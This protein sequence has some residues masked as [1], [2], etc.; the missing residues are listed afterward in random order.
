MTL[1]RNRSAL[2]RSPVI[3]ATA[4][5]ALLNWTIASH[6]QTTAPAANYSTNASSRTFSESAP[7]LLKNLTVSGFYQETVGTFLDSEAIEYNKYSKNSLATLRQLLQIDVNDQLSEHDTF[8]MRDWFVYEPSYPFEDDCPQTL[9]RPPG[10]CNSDFYNQYGI[11]ELWLKDTRGPLELYIGRQIVTWGESLSFRVGDQINPQDTSWAFGFSNLEQSRIP[12][13]MLHPILNLPDAGPLSS[14]FLELVY[15]P[16]VDFLY[17]QVDNSTDTIDGQDQVAGRVNINAPSGSRFAG[18][19]DNR[20]GGPF[21]NKCVDGVAASEPPTSVLG[22]HNFVPDVQFQIPRATWGNNQVGVRLHTLVFNTEI[23]SYYLYSHEYSPVLEVAQ[24]ERLPRS[25]VPG[26]RRVNAMY[27]AFQS[28]A[29]TGNRPIYLPGKLSSWPLVLRAEAFYKNHKEFNWLYPAYHWPKG[30]LNPAAG[31]STFL[32]Q[33]DQ[34]LWLI[35]LDVDNVAIPRVSETGSLTAN[36]EINGTTT[37]S[38]NQYM[39]QAA[40][41]LTRLYHNDINILLNVS[42]SWYWGAIAPT[43]TNIYN[44]DGNTWELFPSVILTPPWTEKYFASLKYIGI[45]GTNKYGIDG[46]IFK[47]KSLFV[48]TFQYNFSLL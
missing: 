47:G 1:N 40:S 21:L 45:L 18:R 39:Q 27:P 29:V 25:G 43:W 38:P 41:N 19:P 46:G 10:D 24:I 37:T 13:W 22:L 33:S 42:E 16:G 48:T 36:L 32:T 7:S 8:F 17:T 26:E 34:V 14:N 35:A 23:A 15:I 4:F 44:P 30:D 5:V 31:G 20:C 9:G 28:F 12:L 6:A 11:R 3:A 2:V